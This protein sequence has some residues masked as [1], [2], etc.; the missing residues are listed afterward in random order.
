MSKLSN[1]FLLLPQW[2]RHQMETY[3]AFLAFVREIHR[4][5]VN[6]PHKGQWRGALM[7][8]LICTLN[9]QLSKQSWGWWF[10]TPSR[11]LWRHCNDEY[12][13]DESTNFYVITTVMII[14]SRLQSVATGK[15]WKIVQSYQLL[16]SLM[17]C[18]S[19]LPENEEISSAAC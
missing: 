10:E 17:T 12:G 16:S 18:V 1:R 9:K 6:S 19:N 15:R 8:S 14:L 4:W 3:S 2:W 11:S 5:P 7:F 13:N